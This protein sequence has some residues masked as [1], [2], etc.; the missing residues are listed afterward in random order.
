M[1]EAGSAPITN[2]RLASPFFKY[3]SAVATA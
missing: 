2:A 3:E 1:R